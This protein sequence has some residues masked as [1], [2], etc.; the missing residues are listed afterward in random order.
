MR[1][2]ALIG[3]RFIQHFPNPLL[4][5]RWSPFP[6]LISSIEANA[7]QAIVSRLSCLVHP[8]CTMPYIAS[9]LLFPSAAVDP[10]EVTVD[11]VETIFFWEGRMGLHRGTSPVGLVA[12]AYLGLRKE[13][14]LCVFEDYRHGNRL[15][16]RRGGHVAILGMTSW[17]FSRLA[18]RAHLRNMFF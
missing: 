17:F 12:V 18:L 11:C 8:D 14:F 10:G 15:L 4:C 16:G 13:T 6:P 3:I 1:G 7:I 5:F 9:Q 2:K